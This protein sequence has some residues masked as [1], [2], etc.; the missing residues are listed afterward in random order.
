MR[1]FNCSLHFYQF[2]LQEFYLP[3][4]WEL[5]FYSD[6]KSLDCYATWWEGTFQAVVPKDLRVA[7]SW[8][9]LKDD[10]ETPVKDG[11]VGIESS[12]STKQSSVLYWLYLFPP[13]LDAHTY[14]LR[15]LGENTRFEEGDRG[16]GFIHEAALQQEN[17][18]CIQTFMVVE[19]VEWV[20]GHSW[21]H[22]KRS[23]YMKFHWTWGHD[24]LN[25]DSKIFSIFS[26]NKFK[27]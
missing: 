2:G 22:E 17:K 7:K 5:I 21:K 10:G 26:S 12:L 11:W 8:E 1:C 25:Q 16:W 24:S 14:D 6:A 15:L 13:P 23:L 19:G 18:R 9:N 20:W 27:M 4:T 3:S